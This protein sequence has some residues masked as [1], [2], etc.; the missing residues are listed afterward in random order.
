MTRAQEIEAYYLE[1]V[2]SR[3]ETECNAFIETF[4]E[5][6]RCTDKELK[7]LHDA[8]HMRDDIMEFQACLKDQEQTV[9][10]IK[11]AETF[12]VKYR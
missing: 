10:A 1:G 5:M 2:R 4:E 6:A 8:I 9:H 7:T 3:M 12:L 11:E